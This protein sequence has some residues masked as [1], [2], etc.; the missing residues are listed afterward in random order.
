MKI[1]IIGTRGIPNN[2]GGFEQTAQ[3][4]SAGLVKKG[5]EVFVYS[6]HDHPYPHN[7]WNG[8]NIVHCY[9]PEKKL[10]TAGQFL[11]DLNCI[12]DARKRD[13]DILLHLGYSSD[14]VWHWRWPRRTI[15]MMNMDGLEWKRSKYGKLTKKFLKRAEWLAAKNSDVLIADSS[16]IQQHLMATYGKESSFIPYGADIFTDNNPI[17]LKKYGLQPNRYYLL[18]A[19]MEPENNIEMVIKGYLAAQKL[20]PLIVVGNVNNKYG[21]YLVKNYDNYNVIF[22]GAI[23]ESTLINNLRYFSALYFHGHSVG[24][25]NPSLLEAMACG[26]TIAAHRNVFNRSVLQ[27]EGDYFSSEREITSLINSPLSAELANE[28]KKLNIEKIKTI[29]NWESI[30]EK[31]ELLM[32]NSVFPVKESVIPIALSASETMG[33]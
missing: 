7:K 9:D 29:Y 23:Y 8:V 16:R 19:R 30:I 3:Y 5:H 24:G 31:Y 4:L 21:K 33:G 25:T 28:R 32:L 15:N 18:I 17:V 12:N 1:G 13:F 14:S 27:R 6:P 20:E 10:G 26:C 2:Y 11:Y 22:V